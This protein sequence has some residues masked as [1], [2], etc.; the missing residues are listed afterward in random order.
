M[1]IYI[2]I[3]MLCCMVSLLCIYT[4]RYVIVITSEEVDG[5]TKL[6]PLFELLESSLQ[7]W[8]C[9]WFKYSEV[10]IWEKTCKRHIHVC[11]TFYT[12]IQY[13]HV[14][15]GDIYLKKTKHITLA[16]HGKF[17]G[18]NILFFVSVGPVRQNFI[19]GK[20]ILLQFDRHQLRYCWF[21]HPKYWR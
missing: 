17:Q 10:T 5:L 11:M 14:C 2:I 4:L 7:R 21:M 6:L 20:S 8:N 12:D 13:S 15:R 3:L 1:Y 19:T 9:W 18:V 16:I